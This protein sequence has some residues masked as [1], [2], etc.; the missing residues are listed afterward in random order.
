MEAKESIATGKKDAVSSQTDR[1]LVSFFVKQ[2]DEEFYERLHAFPMGDDLYCVDNS[3]F[4][5]YGV[6]L[7]DVVFAPPTDGAPTY[8]HTVNRRGHS[9]YRVRLPVGQGHDIFLARWDKFQKLGCTFEGSGVSPS[10]L[11]SIDI[12]PFANVHDVYKLLEEGEMIGAWV[13]EEGNYC[14]ED[15]RESRDH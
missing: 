14:P 4:Y 1:V 9:T 7:G 2:N 3:P 13:F 6:S 12:P 15:Q 10:R 8:K 5:A 11:Y